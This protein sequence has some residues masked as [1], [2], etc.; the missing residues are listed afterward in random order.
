MEDGGQ[1]KPA[2]EA[3]LE[4]REVAGKM[5][6][7][8]PPV[9]AD[10]IPFQIAQDGVDPLECRVLCAAPATGHGHHLVVADDLPDGLEGGYSLREHG[11]R[12]R[13]APLGPGS[14]RLAPEVLHDR[15][16]DVEH[17]AL[18]KVP[19]YTRTTK[20]TPLQARAF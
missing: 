8:H 5:L 14:D 6:S 20:P 9:H 11:G 10:H 13:Q 12:L 19:L 7:A 4:L 16:L 3:P 2:V 17:P 15:D 18:I 1:V